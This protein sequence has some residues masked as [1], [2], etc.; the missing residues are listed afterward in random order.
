[1]LQLTTSL[2]GGDELA[3]SI[4]EVTKSAEMALRGYSKSPQKQKTLKHIQLPKVL[5]DDKAFRDECAHLA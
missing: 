1:M 2:E 3:E 5:R 4:R